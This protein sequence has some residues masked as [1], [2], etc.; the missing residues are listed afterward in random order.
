MF[1]SC[2]DEQLIVQKQYEKLYVDL[3]PPKAAKIIDSALVLGLPE[4]VF[5][6]YFPARNSL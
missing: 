2:S 1:L 5:P 6:G 4:V 3:H